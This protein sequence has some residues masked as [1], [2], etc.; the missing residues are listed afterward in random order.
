MY[1]SENWY[2]AQHSVYQETF[3]FA[4]TTEDPSSFVSRLC[5]S[6]QHLQFVPTRWCSGHDVYLPPDLYTATHI[7]VQHESHRPTLKHTYGGP[8]W[9]L[10]H[11][12][13]HFTL[14]I[15]GKT[16]EFT[17]DSLKPTK[18]VRDHD[19]VELP[20]AVSTPTSATLLEL[21]E[22][23]STPNQ[24]PSH[25]PST[26]PAGRPICRPA[27]LFGSLS[28]WCGGTVVTSDFP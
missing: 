22:N 26:T 27:H 16:K 13:K 24:V 14:D 28:D 10:C 23:T 9:V 19:P 1:V 11:F 6:M 8:F 7:Y 2:I 18:L 5:S 3:I 25:P 20:A 21:Q 17:V 12:D 15:N 4:L